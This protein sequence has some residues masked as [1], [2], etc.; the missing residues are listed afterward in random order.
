[1]MT[2]ST[3]VASGGH[4][5]HPGLFVHQIGEDEAPGPSIDPAEAET[6]VDVDPNTTPTTGGL[7]EDD[8]RPAQRDLDEHDRDEEEDEEDGEEAIMDR[9]DLEPHRP[10]RSAFIDRTGD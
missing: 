3:S 9:E 5:L 6:G 7:P 10:Q 2:V 4:L 8:R 1:M